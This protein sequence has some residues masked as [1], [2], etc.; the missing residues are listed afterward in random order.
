[1]KVLYVVARFPQNS[2]SYVD[3]EIAYAVRSGIQVEVWSPA[4]GYGDEPTV[5][6]RRGDL[7][8]ALS[9]FR[10]DIVHIHHMTTAEYHLHK[11][12]KERVTIRAHSF[13]W[14][15]Q[16]AVSLLSHKCVASV[17]GFPI[18]AKR[19]GGVVPLKV[20]YN[21]QLVTRFLAKDRR[22]IVRLGACL[23]TKRLPDFIEVGN[24]MSGE[25]DFTLGASLGVG[26][27][28]Y[29]GELVK[30][31]RQLGGHV[32][33]LANMPHVEAIALTKIAGIY[34]HTYDERSHEFGMPISVAEAMATGSVV[35]ARSSGAGVRDYLG[36]QFLYSSVDE[37]VRLLQSILDFSD[38]QWTIASDA[39]CA[40][41]SRFR[42][43]Y[44][45]PS[46][47]DAWKKICKGEKACS[48]TS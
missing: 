5:T 45:L 39:S 43:D 15:D 4:P 1:M 13:D 33:I 16:L 23:P 12:L 41:A 14:N 18:L 42:S 26:Q 32:R 19:V 44:V 28:E 21:E 10:P 25:A 2:E 37:A 24:R 46:L 11:L 35:A 8:A 47:I 31:N 30:L 27:E 6:V 20:A 17:F 22:H 38:E 7:E 36:A 48:Q 3:A 40:S 9:A 29:L 34:M